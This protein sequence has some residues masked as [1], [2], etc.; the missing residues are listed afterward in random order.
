MGSLS[1]IQT[2]ALAQFPPG[3]FMARPQ[4]ELMRKYCEQHHE[5][6]HD[7]EESKATA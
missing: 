7:L 6:E 4:F 2:V 1:R 3:L 5:L